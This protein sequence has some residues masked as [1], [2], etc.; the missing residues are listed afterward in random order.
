MLSLCDL[1]FSVENLLCRFYVFEISG[2]FNV[3]QML[4]RKMWFEMFHLW[5]SVLYYFYSWFVEFLCVIGS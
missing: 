5:I 1:A 3:Q 2:V 4:K